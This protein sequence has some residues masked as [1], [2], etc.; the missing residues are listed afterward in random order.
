MHGICHRSSARPSSCPSSKRHRARRITRL[1][2]PWPIEKKPEEIAGPRWHANGRHRRVSPVPLRPCE[3]PL[4]EPTPAVR[5]CPRRRVF[6]PQNAWTILPPKKIAPKCDQPHIPSKLPSSTLSWPTPGGLPAA[7]LC[8]SMRAPTKR[9]GN[10]GLRVVH[11]WPEIRM[12]VKDIVSKHKHVAGVC[13][14]RR[15][16]YGSCCSNFAG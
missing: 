8:Y 6:M 5:P 1:S 15:D 13:L 14:P 10:K 7:P 16:I 4:T 11:S 3:G 2:R 12:C 9:L